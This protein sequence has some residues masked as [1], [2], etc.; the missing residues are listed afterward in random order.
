MKD[1]YRIHC[2]I[3]G[4]IVAALSMDGELTV[5][6]DHFKGTDAFEISRFV[7]A[8]DDWAVRRQIAHVSKRGL[9]PETVDTFNRLQQAKP[10]KTLLPPVNRVL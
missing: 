2:F 5:F 3:D 9:N 6:H 1:P 4:R 7:H 8:L 10:G